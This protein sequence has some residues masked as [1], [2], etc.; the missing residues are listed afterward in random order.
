MGFGAQGLKLQ[1]CGGEGRDSNPRM[2]LPIAVSKLTVALANGDLS[3]R[4][5][6]DSIDRAR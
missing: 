2:V 5:F 4:R 1:G 6:S 3:E